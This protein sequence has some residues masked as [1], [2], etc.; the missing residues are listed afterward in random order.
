MKR[1]AAVKI[2]IVLFALLICQ[3]GLAA[4]K[5]KEVL[6]PRRE[7]IKKY[8][9]RFFKKVNLTQPLVAKVDFFARSNAYLSAYLA[10]APFLD[11]HPYL[12]KILPHFEAVNKIEIEQFDHYKKE[13]GIL[14]FMNYQEKLKAGKLTFYLS[15]LYTLVNDYHGNELSGDMAFRM[16]NI[17]LNLTE[18]A[19][20]D[21]H[22]TAENAALLTVSSYFI[23]FKKHKKWLKR[24]KKILKK[25]TPAHITGKNARLVFQ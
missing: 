9:R 18:S 5:E 24:A 2:I 15:V 12:K 22:K 20:K 4:K 3:P 6:F 19:Y 13:I 7:F 21:K 23:F 8:S 16:W 25:L 10:F 1:K 14:N 11:K 17:L